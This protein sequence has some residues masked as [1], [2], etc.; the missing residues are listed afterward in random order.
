MLHKVI[1]ILIIIDMFRKLDFDQF[2][3]IDNPFGVFV[4]Y[5]GIEFNEA[6]REKYCSLTKNPN[7]FEEML[8]DLQLL[9]KRE[10]SQLLKWRTRILA[11]LKSKEKS[12]KVEFADHEEN[13]VIYILKLDKRGEGRN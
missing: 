8:N 13:Q 5:Q 9:G 7:G 1:V 3:Q 4:D 12:G 6:H 2:I 10:V 11:A